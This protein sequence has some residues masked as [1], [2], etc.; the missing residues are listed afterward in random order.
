MATPRILVGTAS[1]SDPGFVQHWYPRKMAAGDRLAWYSQHFEMVEVNS[2]FYSVP[3]TRMAGRWCEQTPPGFIFNVKLHQLLSRHS[4]DRKMLPPTLQE[5]AQ[6]DSKG[7]V[8][9]TPEIEASMIEEIRRPIDVLQAAGKLGSLLLQL[10]PGFS[11]KMHKL[12]ELD[13]LLRALRNYRVAVELRNRNWVDPQNLTETTE[14]LQQ[15]SVAMVLVDAP[16]ASHF[17]IMPSELNEV[18]NPE[19]TYLRLHGRNARAYTTGKTVATRFNYDYSDSEIDE[20]A[21][22]ANELAAKPRKFMS[23]SII[24]H[25]ITRRTL[26]RA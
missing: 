21:E 24:T 23:F 20:V 2:T 5:E 1:W 18:T 26:P 11:P 12:S 7:R 4:T 3:D 22:R 16:E 10:S 6:V 8:K 9:L 17:T 13:P 15:H 14:F 25:W 19:L